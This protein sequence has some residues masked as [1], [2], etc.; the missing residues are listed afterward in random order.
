M[1]GSWEAGALLGTALNNALIDQFGRL[2][3]KKTWRPWRA[4]R[5]I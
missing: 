4:W 2:P 1:T 5:L 3:T